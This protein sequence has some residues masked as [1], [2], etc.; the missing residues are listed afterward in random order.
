VNPITAPI[1]IL[2]MSLNIEEAGFYV[3]GSVGFGKTVG[4]EK[5]AGAFSWTD[6]RI[7]SYPDPRVYSFYDTF[8]VVIHKV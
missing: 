3:D 1:S 2:L 5:Y 7:L 8:R 6:T 4:A